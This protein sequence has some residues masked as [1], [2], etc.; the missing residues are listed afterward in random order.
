MRYPSDNAAEVYVARRTAYRTARIAYACIYGNV[1][2]RAIAVADSKNTVAV[3]FTENAADNELRT[4][5]ALVLERRLHCHLL[6]SES[7]CCRRSRSSDVHFIL[8]VHL[9]RAVKIRI[10]HGRAVGDGE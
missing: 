1:A 3:G 6:D 7:A 8:C 2:C 4:L 10:L 9:E 5:S